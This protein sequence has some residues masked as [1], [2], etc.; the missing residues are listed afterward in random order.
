MV[1]VALEL[2][3]KGKEFHSMES[4]LRQSNMKCRAP[5]A[6]V[7]K[8]GTHDFAGLLE[9]NKTSFSYFYS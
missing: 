9:D 8:R 2:G 7:V 3:L 6:K 1:E 5:V 4:I